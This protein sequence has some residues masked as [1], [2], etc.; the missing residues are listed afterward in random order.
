MRV[1]SEALTQEV[2]RAALPTPGGII[3][4][5]WHLHFNV[6]FCTSERV[7]QRSSH[8]FDT[9]ASGWGLRGRKQASG[10]HLR[11]L[12]VVL[13]AFLSLG[14]EKAEATIAPPVTS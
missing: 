9:G 7:G 13:I 5:R 10:E 6:T 14:L 1:A 12:S 4:R 3:R 8:G 11:N 2:D